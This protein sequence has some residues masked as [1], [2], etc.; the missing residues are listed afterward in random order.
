MIAL[1]YGADQK[2][3]LHTADGA[4]PPPKT[5]RGL[6]PAQKFAEILRLL[7]AQD[8]VVLESPTVGSSGAEPELIREVVQTAPHR[9]YKISARAVK[10]YV[11]TNNLGKI[12]DSQAAE[13]IHQIAISNPAAIQPWQYRDKEESRVHKSVRPYDKRGYKGSEVDKWMARLPP[14]G[15]LPEDMQRLLGNGKKRHPDY[16]R[17]RV[18]PFAMALEERRSCSRDGYE[19][20]IGLHGHGYP[21]FYRRCTENLRQRVAKDLAGAKLNSEVTPGQRKESWKITRKMIRRLYHLAQGTHDPR[22]GTHHPTLFD[23]AET[24]T[25]TYSPMKGTP[26]PVAA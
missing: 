17:A 20:V 15:L 4:I 5:S 7:L 8:D 14:F 26:Y 13:I 3:K 12:S 18:L 16:A 24:E 9:L 23:E 11:K 1:D 2:L 21:S 22:K 10:N 6:T 19:W 25:G